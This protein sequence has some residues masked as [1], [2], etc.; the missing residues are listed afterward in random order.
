MVAKGLPLA[1]GGDETAVGALCL[2]SEEEK[3]FGARKEGEMRTKKGEAGLIKAQERPRPGG[4]E[5]HMK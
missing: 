5:T 4:D 1:E 2:R 3:R